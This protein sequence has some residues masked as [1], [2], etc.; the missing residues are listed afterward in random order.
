MIIRSENPNGTRGHTLFTARADVDIE[1]ARFQ[2]LGRTDAFSD[3]NNTKLD[4]NGNVVQ[5]GTNQIGRYA[6]HMHHLIGPENPANRGYQFKLIGNAVVGAR[7]WGITVHDS[8]FGLIDQNVVYDAQGAGIATEDGSE[9]GNVFSNNM[10]IRIQGTHVDG[11]SGTAKG[12]FGRGGSGFWFRRGGNAVVGNVAADNTYA[13]FVIDG[14]NSFE[15]TFPLYRGADKRMAG[16]GYTSVAGPGTLFAN[17]E[18][19]GMT[20]TGVWV[21]FPAGYPVTTDQPPTYFLGTK[22]WNVHSTG[23]VAY[24]TSQ[25]T[26]SRLLILGDSQGLDRRDA[27]PRG[28]DLSL[29]KNLNLV[30]QNSRIENYYEGIRAPTGDASVPGIE[31]PTI[32]KDSTLKNY[33]NITVFPARDNKSIAGNVLE[34]RNDKFVMIPILGIQ[35][36]GTNVRPPANISMEHAGLTNNLVFPSIV[37]VYDYNQVPGDD[38][39]VYYREQDASYVLPQ[40]DPALNSNREDGVVGTP[41]PGLTNAQAWQLYGLALAG[42]VAPADADGSRPDI[43]GLVAPIATPVDPPRVVLITPWNYAPVTSSYIHIRSNVIGQLP[44]GAAVYYQLDDSAPMSNIT[45]GALYEVTVGPHTL[46]AY[47]GDSEGHLLPGTTVTTSSF[48]ANF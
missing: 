28:M 4:A 9:I 14:Y 44:P 19:Y 30:I 6:L 26:F 32:I 11:K 24:Y 38:F 39:Q 47:I 23:V 12:D 29:Y 42:A 45:S 10:T 37:R 33:I 5:L 21:T 1:Y 25:L 13:G 16:Q 17:N 7:K 8:D 22:I 36:F 3:I 46:R 41:L 34:V 15:I 40:T 43:N 48:V 31:R 20:P 18:A 27:G 35:P 2:D